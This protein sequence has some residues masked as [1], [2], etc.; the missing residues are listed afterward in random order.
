MSPSKH[1]SKGLFQPSLF[2]NRMQC[3]FWNIT[4]VIRNDNCSFF[5]RMLV[6]KVRTSCMIIYLTIRFDNFF[7]FLKRHALHLTYIVYHIIRI[8]LIRI[9]ILF[10]KEF[11]NKRT[12]KEVPI[13]TSRFASDRHARLCESVK[14]KAKTPRFQEIP[15]RVV[16]FLAGAEG[17]EPSARGFGDRCSTD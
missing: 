4:F 6:T 1:T 11:M 5:G 13:F 10:A 16:S 2:H 8:M 12:R 3:S 14:Q 17:F 7:R 15:N 9:L